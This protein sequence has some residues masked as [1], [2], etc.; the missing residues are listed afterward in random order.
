MEVR[1]CKDPI[2]P[3]CEKYDEWEKWEQCKTNKCGEV[4]NRKRFRKCLVEFCSEKSLIEEEK[5]QKVIST[6][7]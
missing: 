3:I 7:T 5:C 6:Q 1:Q 4:G 2:P